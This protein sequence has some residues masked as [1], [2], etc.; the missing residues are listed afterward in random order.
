MAIRGA[1]KRRVPLAFFQRPTTDQSFVK[2]IVLS[3]SIQQLPDTDLG[4][5]SSYNNETFTLMED[6]N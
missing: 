2:A 1:T 4:F 5:Q 6:L 3:K